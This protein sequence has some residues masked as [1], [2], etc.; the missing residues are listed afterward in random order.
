MRDLGEGPMK[1]SIFIIDDDPSTLWYLTQLLSA[2]YSIYIEKYGQ[3]AISRIKEILPDLILLDIIMP[4]MDGYEVIK[5][6]KANSSISH[7]PVIFLTA[8]DNAESEFDGLSLGAVDYI[9]K[10]F[11]VPILKKRIELHI[12]LE[13]Q[14]KRL[15]EQNKRLHDYND[16]LQRLV[17][18]KTEKVL[19]LQDAILSTIT[20]FVEFR[21]S[22][23]GGHIERTQLYIKA[24]AEKMIERKIYIDEAAFWDVNLLVQSAQLHDVGKIKI[25]DSI[26]NKPGKLTDEEFEIVKCHTVFGKEAINKITKKVGEND[27]LQQAAILTY[28]HH[29]R[30]DGSGYPLGLKGRAIPLQG[31]LMAIADVYDALISERPYK[32]AF[33]HEKA[34]EI[35][36]EKKGIL[37]DPI[38]AELFA[39][40]SKKIYDISKMSTI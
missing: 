26:L 11:N 8:K 19:R 38:L 20:E 33:T 27:L 22:L 37:F 13:E 9:A 31:R 6:I 18:Q 12:L 7:I 21:D 32:K 23:I 10:P 29:E 28:S 1:K 35:I 30:W 15:I 40:I 2:D 16:N 34:V 14:N 4:E 5:L 36:L 17:S 24:L 39:E 25:S 3:E